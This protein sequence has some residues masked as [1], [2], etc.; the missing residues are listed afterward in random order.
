[1][2]NLFRV[3][4]NGVVKIADF[5]LSRNL[6]KGH[7]YKAKTSRPLP[8]RWMAIECLIDNAVFTIK[9]DVVSDVLHLSF[10]KHGSWGSDDGLFVCVMG[11]TN[12]D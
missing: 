9:S 8:V 4:E 6:Y 2:F 5:G 7:Y 1:M 12:C 11:E 10:V 3:D